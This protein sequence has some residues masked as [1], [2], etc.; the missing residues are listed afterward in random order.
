MFSDVFIVRANQAAA[1]SGRCLRLTRPGLGV[2]ALFRSARGAQ[3]AGLWY[4]R[5]SQSTGADRTHG[6][7][8]IAGGSSRA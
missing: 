7:Q 5:L 3:P 1:T 2:P 4:R 8:S 6:R